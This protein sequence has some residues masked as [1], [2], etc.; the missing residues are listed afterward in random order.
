MHRYQP[1]IHIAK[2]I[3]KKHQERIFSYD[4]PETA[5]IAVTAYQ[6]DQV[7][8]YVIVVCYATCAFSQVTQLK[9]DYNQFAKAFRETNEEHEM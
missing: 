9:I 3:S 8:H 6:N 4:F 1:R 5:F 7:F 2:Y